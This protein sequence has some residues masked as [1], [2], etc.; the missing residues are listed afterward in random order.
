MKKNGADWTIRLKRITDPI[1]FHFIKFA[2]AS[3]DCLHCTNQMGFSCIFFSWI[4]T[5]RSYNHNGVVLQ[6]VKEECTLITMDLTVPYLES[7]KS[8]FQTQRYVLLLQVDISIPP[9]TSQ[10]LLRGHGH[11]QFS[12]RLLPPLQQMVPKKD[13]EV[14]RIGVFYGSCFRCCTTAS[15]AYCIKSVTTCEFIKQFRFT[16]VLYLLVCMHWYTACFPFALSVHLE[17][18][19]SLVFINWDQYKP[20][21]L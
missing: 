5:N 1:D 7:K 9:E 14:E 6:S 18:F 10:A 12:S 17:L 3:S 21:R 13:S 4:S 15:L 19:S 20:E 11:Y 16:P 8:S 2:A